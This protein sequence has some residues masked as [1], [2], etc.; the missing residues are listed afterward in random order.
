M[1][2]KKSRAGAACGDGAPGAVVDL[3][4]AGRLQRRVWRAFASL[5]GAELTTAEL[6]C[7]AYPRLTGQP[8][9]KHRWAIVRA[10]QRVALRVRRDRP[11]GVVFRAMDSKSVSKPMSLS[12]NSE[13]DQ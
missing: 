5:P 8:S 3:H 2:E 4:G 1:A 11:G 9:R 12:D 6:A 7:W 10:A 13:S